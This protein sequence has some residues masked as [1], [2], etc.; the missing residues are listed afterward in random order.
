L[1]THFLTEFDHRLVDLTFVPKVHNGVQMGINE[2]LFPIIAPR[3]LGEVLEELQGLTAI[4]TDGSKTEGLVEFGI[5][6]DDRDSYRF[7]LPGHY[8]IFT[9]EMCAIHFACD[10]IESKP[11]GAYIILTDSLTSIEGLRSTGIS[12]RTN[13]MLF[14]TRRS[15]RYLGELGYN[16]TLMWIPS[17]W[18]S[19]GPMYWKMSD[20][21]L[22]HCFRTKLD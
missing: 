22:E 6:S 20:R 3:L 8:G 21:F 13:D 19:N 18:V 15:L 1:R 2:S 9:A 14:R 4:Y 5:F 11:I 12:Y 7:R 16:I 17:H 10:L